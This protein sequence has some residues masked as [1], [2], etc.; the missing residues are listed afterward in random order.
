MAFNNSAERSTEGS[1]I[2]GNSKP[3]WKAD[4]FLNLYINDR[5]GVRRKL[6]AVPLKLSD[7]RQSK[8]IEWLNSDEKNVDLLREKLIIDFQSTTV[9]ADATGFAL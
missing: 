8:L 1:S 5:T 2:N 7:A 4:A 3:N 6:G 9:D